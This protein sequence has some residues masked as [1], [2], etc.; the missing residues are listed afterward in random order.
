MPPM[1]SL[2][3]MTIGWISVRSN[4]SSAA[5]RPAGPPPIMIALFMRCPATSRCHSL[6]S[7]VCRVIR[8]LRLGPRRR[9]ATGVEL[10]REI[11]RF[12]E[13]LP[14]VTI[15]NIGNTGRYQEFCARAGQHMQGTVP[16]TLPSRRIVRIACATRE[17]DLRDDARPGEPGPRIEIASGDRNLVARP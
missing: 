14:S 5:V 7:A 6:V 8:V 2:F 11:V 12:T 1:Y 13:R 17:K 3:S 10:K 9:L 16:L 4:N 15:L